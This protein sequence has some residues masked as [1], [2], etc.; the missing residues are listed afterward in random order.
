MKKLDNFQ[1]GMIWGLVSGRHKEL[2]AQME[3]GEHVSIPNFLIELETDLDVLWKGGEIWIAE[4][5]LDKNLCKFVI[6]AENVKAVQEF[7]I[8]VDDM[9]Y[10]GEAS[11]Q[12]RNMLI[13]MRNTAIVNN[14]FD[15]AIALSHAVAWMHRMMEA[16]TL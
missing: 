12:L 5:E 15:D 3:S 13:Q 1:Q 11:K 9:I 4:T 6:G 8:T 2:K 16:V 7:E 14:R 10:D